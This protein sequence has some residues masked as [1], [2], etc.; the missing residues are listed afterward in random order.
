MQRNH[1]TKELTGKGIMKKTRDEEWEGISLKFYTSYFF[2]F[3]FRI[4]TANFYVSNVHFYDSRNLY[5]Y[6]MQFDQITIFSFNF[7]TSLLTGNVF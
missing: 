6:I 7:L 4:F 3:N 5:M 1:I 2:G